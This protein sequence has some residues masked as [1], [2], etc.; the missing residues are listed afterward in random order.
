VHGKA[1]LSRFCPIASVGF[2]SNNLWSGSTEVFL[3]S[4]VRRVQK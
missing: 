1:D 3:Q 2:E 4:L